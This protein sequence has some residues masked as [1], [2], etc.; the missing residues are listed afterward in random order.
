MT[1]S[2]SSRKQDSAENLVTCHT[3]YSPKSQINHKRLES[4]EHLVKKLRQLNSTYDENQ[5]DYIA[6]LCETSNP[7]HR[8]ISEILVASG[9][10]LR[11]LNSTLTNFQLHPLGLPINPQL[12]LVLEQT[13][14]T[15]LHGQECSIKKL[16]KDK[17]HRKLIFD[18]VNEI[19]VGKLASMGHSYEP[20][21]R[22]KKQARKYLNAQML[23]RDLCSEMEQ[24]QAKKSGYGF[25]ENEEDSLK[26]ILCEEL[27]HPAKN[28]T[29]S[30]SEIS[31]T[32]LDVER[33]IFKALV[34]EILQGEA[35]GLQIK[36]RRC[37]MQLSA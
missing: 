37:C 11:D 8:Y 13:K 33:L 31:G 23:L 4:I 26:S 21:L 19:L 7:D 18:A 15:T 17:F 29:N 28:W 9:F 35:F 1:N 24:L 3:G 34:D 5:T 30:C 10:L 20:W 27:V 6:S 12:F 32:V 16:E 36:S 22:P 14:S 25:E 2:N